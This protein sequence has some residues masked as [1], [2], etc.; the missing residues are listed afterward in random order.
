MIQTA[1]ETIGNDVK[2]SVLEAYTQTKRTGI[3]V[4]CVLDDMFSGFNTARKAAW[5]K[6]TQS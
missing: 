2:G 4:A 5:L 1:T 6:L 3:C